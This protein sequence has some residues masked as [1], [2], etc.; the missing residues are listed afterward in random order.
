LFGAGVDEA[1][2]GRICRKATTAQ[3]RDVLERQLRF[4]PKMREVLPFPVPAPEAMV[5]D[6]LVY[7]KLPGSPMPA[8]AYERFDSRE[9]ARDIASFM[10]TLHA[11]PVDACLGWGVSDND[12]TEELLCA[13]HRALPWLS[14]ADRQS[15]EAWRSRFNRGEY[16]SVV[17]HGD[18]W[19]ENILID[20]DTH[21]LVGV[22]D[23]EATSLGDPAWDLATQ[24]HCGVEF[25]RLVFEAYPRRDPGMWGRA[26]QLF[27]L[28]QFEGL[29]WAVR[30]GDAA[31][32][33]ESIGKLQRAGVLSR[34]GDR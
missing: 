32:F 25:A 3:A 33:D 9:L 8:D 15:A 26:Q 17:V 27:Q 24:L 12:R 28:R 21:R 16:Q 22:I 1:E 4:L 23:F 31:E 11:L 7:R 10:G 34:S 5:D 2:D 30:H 14:S 18:L 13:F 29:D 20:P 6:V 19:Y